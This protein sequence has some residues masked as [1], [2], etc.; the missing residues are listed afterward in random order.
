MTAACLIDVY[1]VSRFHKWSIIV[2]T[3]KKS[4]FLNFN[5]VKHIRCTTWNNSLVSISLG[6]ISCIIKGFVSPLLP[7]PRASLSCLKQWVFHLTLQ[8]L[9]NN[10]KS[11]HP[12]HWMGM[13]FFQGV[14]FK[15]LNKFT[16]QTKVCFSLSGE[17]LQSAQS[18]LLQNQ[19]VIWCVPLRGHGLQR[20]TEVLQFA[21]QYVNISID[22]NGI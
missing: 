9:T 10:K 14:T 6:A 7:Q 11:N 12:D 13:I 22:C 18:K 16:K 21:P 4:H 1:R 19:I 3:I 15:L 5:L 20:P 8:C 17:K 2:V